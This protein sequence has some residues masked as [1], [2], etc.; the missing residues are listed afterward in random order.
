MSTS[1]AEKSRSRGLLVDR[2]LFYVN[3][4]VIEMNYIRWN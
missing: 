1:R 2:P 3:Y 4:P